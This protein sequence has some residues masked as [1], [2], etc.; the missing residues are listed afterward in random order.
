VRRDDVDLVRFGDGGDVRLLRFEPPVLA[1]DVG[2]ERVELEVPF[3]ARHQARNTLA[4]LAAYRALGLPLA[5]AAE[6]AAEIRFSRWRGEEREL[7]GGGLLIND[8][9]NANPV[10][11]RAALEHLVERAHGRRT[12]A[13][14]G[15]M[16]ELGTDAPRYHREIGEAA[17]A[18]GVDVVVAVGGELAREYGGR[19]VATR[20]AV[21]LLRELVR[22]DDVVLVKASRAAA[23]E[24]VAEALTGVAA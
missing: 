12:I 3:R 13:V 14:L 17:A 24:T 8:A 16:A 20:E 6:G 1:A 18:L 23:L 15:E 19:H 7:P 4:A 10:S 21:A 11:M 5:R 2:G 9:Y 22:G